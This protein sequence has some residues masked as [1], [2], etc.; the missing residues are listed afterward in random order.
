MPICMFDCRL[1]SSDKMLVGSASAQEG[2]PE[3]EV[4]DTIHSQFRSY[5][6]AEK[7]KAF[8][9][10]IQIISCF[11]LVRTVYITTIYIYI[12]IHIHL[13]SYLLTHSLTHYIIIY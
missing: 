12:Y 1:R 8:D 6:K 3:W 2:H 10:D 9:S 7:L 11:L 13:L 5:W 4:A